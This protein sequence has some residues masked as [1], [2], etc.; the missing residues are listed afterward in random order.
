MFSLLLKDLI[1]D[2]YLH[3]IGTKGSMHQT[4]QI[5]YNEIVAFGFQ[6]YLDK[7]SITNSELYLQV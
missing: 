5:V 2:F 4:E 1:S 3:E 6:I 7:L